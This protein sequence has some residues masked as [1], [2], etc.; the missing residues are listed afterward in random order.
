MEKE[1]YFGD[2]CPT[3]KYSDL[4]EDETPCDDCLNN[5]S[6]TDS[7]KPIRWKAKES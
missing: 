4:D 2:Y 6:A 7:H 1:V 3:C 5:P